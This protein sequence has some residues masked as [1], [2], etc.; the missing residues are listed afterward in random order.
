M[1]WR[2]APGTCEP[3]DETRGRAG[4]CRRPRALIVGTSDGIGLAFTELLLREGWTVAGVS[5]SASRLEAPA[6]RH[7]QRGC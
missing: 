7:E 3:L 2:A 5:R 6:Y 4:E 1:P